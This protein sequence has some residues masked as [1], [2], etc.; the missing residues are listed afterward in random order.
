MRIVRAVGLENHGHVGW[1][2]SKGCWPVVHKG[3]LYSGWVVFC[4][5]PDNLVVKPHTVD[6]YLDM[7]G[8]PVIS[9]YH[10]L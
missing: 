7:F 5:F 3:E 2:I 10:A 6:V 8:D 1:G 9:Y 4:G